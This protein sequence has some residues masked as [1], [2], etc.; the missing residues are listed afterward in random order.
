[1]GTYPPDTKP[2]EVT[3]VPPELRKLALATQQLQLHR[4]HD[5]AEIVAALR[6]LAEALPLVTKDREQIHA[7]DEAADKLETS[8]DSAS[9]HA[10][11]VRVA[12]DDALVLLAHAEPRSRWR[13]D[14]YARAVTAFT[15]TVDQIET[16]VGLLQQHEHVEAAFVA[17]VRAF[18]IA[19]G[20]S[21]E[22]TA[23]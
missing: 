4:D 18:E 13:I 12:L 15:D 22:S 19:V 2:P 6:A 23:S 8:P 20:V 9:V 5:H 17:A 7:I 11:Q 16:D 10:D 3:E 14:E 21:V 1:V